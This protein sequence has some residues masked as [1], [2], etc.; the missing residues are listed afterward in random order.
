MNKEHFK[1]RCLVQVGS[2][3]CENR[4]ESQTKQNYIDKNIYR[5]IAHCDAKVMSD[6]VI[7]TCLDNLRLQH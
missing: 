6:L 1:F 2:N 5:V 7:Y 3:Q 4:R